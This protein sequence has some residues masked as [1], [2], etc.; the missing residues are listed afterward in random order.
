M[1]EIAR[2]TYRMLGLIFP[3]IYFIYTKKVTLFILVIGLAIFAL[4]DIL[5]I[6]IPSLSKFYF[7]YLKW[8]SKKKEKRGLTGTTYLLISFLLTVF[9]FEKNIA[10]AAMTFSV[11][12]DAASSLIGKKFGKNKLIGKRT[13][14][15][16]VAFF[17]ASLIAGLIFLYFGLEIT[18]GIMFIGILAATI[19]ELLP[20]QI[21]D[22]LTISIV[23][24]LVM[25]LI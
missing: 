20:I 2:K 6:M 23:S 9:L 19:A 18:Y 22:N 1:G 16:S 12:G 15:G 13:F 4:Y 5:K 3:I 7:K 8:I 17:I 25:S 21:D 11:M 14:E 24:G 10:I